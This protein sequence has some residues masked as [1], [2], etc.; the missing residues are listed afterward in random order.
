MAGTSRAPSTSAR[1]SPTSPPDVTDR[2]AHVLGPEHA[3]RLSASY[4]GTNIVVPMT[5]TGRG[6]TDGKLRRNVGDGLF[7][8]LVFHFGG[9]RIYV[10]QADANRTHRGKGIDAKQVARL[11][12]RGWSVARIARH[13]GCS[14]RTIFTKRAQLKL[15]P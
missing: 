12:A 10:P 11:T 4:G 3:E 14:D 15:K 8:L 5:L 7:A 6:F 13:L 1:S 2:L 9:T